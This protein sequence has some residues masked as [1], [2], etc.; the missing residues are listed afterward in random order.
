MAEKLTDSMFSQ[1][2]YLLCSLFQ[3]NLISLLAHELDGNNGQNKEET[4]RIVFL[5]RFLLANGTRTAWPM[6]RKLDIG[7]LKPSPVAPP[8]F[9]VG[10]GL[11]GGAKADPRGHRSP[12]QR[13]ARAAPSSAPQGLGRGQGMFDRPSR[14]QEGHPCPA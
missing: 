13:P 14:G 5:A 4:G 12:G 7:A 2:L 3:K 6:S 9:K 11:L 8:W 10:I 1:T